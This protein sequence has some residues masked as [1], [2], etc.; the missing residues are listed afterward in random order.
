MLEWE[1]AGEHV[2]ETLGVGGAV[3]EVWC[4]AG[5]LT[6]RLRRSRCRDG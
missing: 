2:A 1:T 3:H 6:C 4:D 5:V